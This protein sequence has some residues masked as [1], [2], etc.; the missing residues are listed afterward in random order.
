VLDNETLTTT[1][2]NTGP[3]EFP[4]RR[5]CL[6]LAVVTVAFALYVSLLPFRLQ[7][8]P[9]GV[10]WADFQVAMSSWPPSVP[11]ANFLANVLLFV[12][13][14]FGLCGA[15]RADRDRRLTLGTVVVVLCCSIA[16]SLTAEFLQEFAP[17]RVVSMVDVVAQTVGSVIGIIAWLGAGPELIQWIR[18]TRRRTHRDRLTRA[19]AA[20]AALWAFAN[21][22]PFD[23]TLNVDRLGQ[24]WREGDIVLTPFGSTLPLSRVL[25]DAAVTTVSAVPLGGLV[26]VGW[27]RR[28]Q[29]RSIPAALGIGVTA[30]VTLEAAQV[31]IRS[32][33]ADITDVMC[34][35]VG[36]VAG[37]LVG[38]RTLDRTLGGS[39][40]KASSTGPWIALFAWCVMLAAYHWQPFDFAVNEDLIRQKL[41]HISLVPLAGYLS[42]S[43]LNA[44]NTLLAKLGLAIP[45]GTFL[46]V[47]LGTTVPRWLVTLLW[48]GLSTIVFGAMEL[49]QF[50]LPGRVP[51]PSDVGLGVLGAGLGVWLARWLRSGYESKRQP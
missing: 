39:E 24:R 51:D 46:A 8:V 49:G 37:A 26:L 45:F 10:A 22:A 41:S 16:S 27:Q 35:T 43:D 23:I 25:W 4:T 20:Y 17:R 40:R 1:A 19:L 50:F 47:A 30:L 11:R 18:E 32:H 38:V 28:D 15:L 2:D 21:L 33:S 3:H 9:L 14:G 44:F 13:V 7:P 12:P 36:L 34:G 29:R 42:G 5:A 31:F 48:V 6:A